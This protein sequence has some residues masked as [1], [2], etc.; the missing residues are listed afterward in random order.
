[1]DKV[2]SALKDPMYK[3]VVQVK[4]DLEYQLDLLK[5]DNENLR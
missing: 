5:K 1:M 4:E 2:E 3:A